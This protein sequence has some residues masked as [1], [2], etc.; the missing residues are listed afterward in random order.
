[1]KPS[2]SMWWIAAGTLLVGLFGRR[3]LTFEWGDLWL[4]LVV[5]GAW[6]MGYCRHAIDGAKK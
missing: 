3:A 4:G 1:M 5:V 6:A 2:E